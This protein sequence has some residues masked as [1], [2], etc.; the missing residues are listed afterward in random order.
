[1]TVAKTTVEGSFLDH[2]EVLRRKLLLTGL[3]FVVFSGTALGF[4]GEIIEVI[5]SA[6]GTTAPEF[7]YIKPQEKV[8]TYFQMAAFVGAIATFPFLLAQLTTFIW[9]ALNRGE[10]RVVLAS[11]LLMQLLF[12]GGVAFSGGIVA[13]FA[14]R[15]FATFAAGDDIAPVWSIG[16]YIKLVRGIVFGITLVFQTPLIMI[17]L[18]TSGVVPLDR[19]KKLRKVALVVSAIAGGVLTPPDVFTQL[20]VGTVL[21]ALFELSLFVSGI[22]ARTNRTIEDEND[23]DDNANQGG[24]NGSS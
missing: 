2:L 1:M 13:P 15:F 7:V 19:L 5:R 23:D 14:V 8:I 24:R 22:V 6:A 4:A 3:I 21:Y 12:F 9:P 10:R 20:A 17:S 11:Y 16:E 18:A